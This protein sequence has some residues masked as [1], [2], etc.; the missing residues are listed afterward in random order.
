[1]KVLSFSQSLSVLGNLK[2]LSIFERLIETMAFF[3]NVVDLQ[4]ALSACLTVRDWEMLTETVE[5][6]ENFTPFHAIG[7][8]TIDRTDC[9]R[10]RS[11]L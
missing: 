2:T 11:K 8:G 10:T 5:I 1:M 6:P 7:I 9:A 3:T 4:A